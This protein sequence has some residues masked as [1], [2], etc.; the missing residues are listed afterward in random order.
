MSNTHQAVSVHI[1]RRQP[2]VLNWSLEDALEYLENEFPSAEP[3]VQAVR[4]SIKTSADQIPAVEFLI[5]QARQNHHPD[6]DYKAKESSWAVLDELHKIVNGESPM[7]ALPTQADLSKNREVLNTPLYAWTIE[8][9]LAVAED[10][11]N[12]T[13]D[14]VDRMRNFVLSMTEDQK[15]AFI[16]YLSE[17]V[18]KHREE[19]AAAN[20]LMAENV[21]HYLDIVAHNGKIPNAYQ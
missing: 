16:R 6:L 4:D 11:G 13:P 5:E 8:D 14:K 1:M 3:E 2:T 17:A 19:L 9:V 18:D 20:R 10:Q 21:L 15:P 7:P 12:L